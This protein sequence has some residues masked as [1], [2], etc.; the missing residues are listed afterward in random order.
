MFKDDNNAEIHT[1]LIAE[2]Q[3]GSRLFIIFLMQISSANDG[4]PLF[5]LGDFNRT[6]NVSMYSDQALLLRVGLTVGVILEIVTYPNW[7][8]Y[9][10]DTIANEAYM[11]TYISDDLL[12]IYEY[13]ILNKLAFCLQVMLDRYEFADLIGAI[14]LGQSGVKLYS[15][16][17][18]RVPN[19]RQARICYDDFVINA[20]ERPFRYTEDSTMEPQVVTSIVCTSL[21]ITCLCVTIV[22]YSIFGELRSIPGKN[23]IVLSVHLLVAQCLYQFAF[24]E[25]QHPRLCVAF[26][27]MMHFFWLT[28]ILWMSACTI[29]MFRT[30][31]TKKS[32]RSK[33]SCEPQVCMYT[34]YCYTLA[35]IPV[36]INIG[37]SL[38]ESDG[39]SIGYGGHICYISSPMMVGL[40]FALP[41]GIIVILNLIFFL[42]VMYKISE[43]TMRFRKST[44]R[45]NAIIYVRLSSLTG[46]TWI[47]GYIYIWTGFEPLEY[48][49]IILNAGQGVLIFISFICNAKIMHLYQD[50]FRRQSRR[51]T[52]MCCKDRVDHSIPKQPRVAEALKVSASIK[53]SAESNKTN[54]SAN[55]L[56]SPDGVRLASGQ[57]PACITVCKSEDLNVQVAVA[58]E[59][60]TN[61]TVS[62]A[63][64]AIP[65]F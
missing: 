56:P 6:F 58:N 20:P 37:I 5:Q 35:A 12:N 9:V 26:G 2:N 21:S 33:R 59:R 34:L 45:T 38:K 17:F 4:T 15:G 63:D 40:T 7:N 28:S 22:T 57:L 51:L 46:T 3:S 19:T 8:I 36:A 14:R 39:N 30:F 55:V 13:P 65:R 48:V 54:L 31:V 25:T 62:T 1:M 60:E 50:F 49:F 43:S 42:V 18:I 53:I 47:F 29:H 11:I 41:V 16:E 61:R 24:T 27:I 10:Y 32:F 64:L 52:R 44:D 23:N